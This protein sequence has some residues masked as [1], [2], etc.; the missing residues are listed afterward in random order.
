MVGHKVS[1]LEAMRMKLAMAGSAEKAPAPGKAVAQQPLK[2]TG[3]PAV[4]AADR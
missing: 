4:I 2:P 1:N 3:A